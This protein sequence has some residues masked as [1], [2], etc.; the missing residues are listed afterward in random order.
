MNARQSG[1][2][3]FKLDLL[4]VLVMCLGSSYVVFTRCAWLDCNGTNFC[5][6]ADAVQPLSRIVPLP[7]SQLSPY[8]TII[9]MRLIILAFF[10]HY[11]VTHPV[12]SA[13]GLWLT[14]V[15]CEIWFAFSWVLDQFPKWSPINRETYIDRLSARSIFLPL[16]PF[17]YICNDHINV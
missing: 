13:I 6:L 12:D 14:S 1:C 3:T 7:K 9:I 15:I 8:R 10:F 5:R 2:F 16:K 4:L 17:H 11:R